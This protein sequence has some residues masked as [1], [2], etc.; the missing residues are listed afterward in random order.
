VLRAKRADDGENLRARSGTGI[1]ESLIAMIEGLFG[2][3]VNQ[4]AHGLEF[5]ARRHEVLTQNIANAAT[6]GY[7]GRDL[8]FEDQLSP[9]LAPAP[10]DGARVAGAQV[11]YTSEGAAAADGNDVHV[12]REMARLA[13]NTLFHQA[14]VQVLA[15]HF[16]VLKQAIAGHV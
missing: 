10:D 12:D 5:A 3:V 1:A 7:R 13:E 15:G 8:L 2:S 11:V 4:L 6:P 16:S 9:L 14:L